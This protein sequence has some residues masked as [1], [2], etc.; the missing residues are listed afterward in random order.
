[1]GC[2]GVCVVWKWSWFCGLGVIIIL[3]IKCWR[4]LSCVWFLMLFCWLLKW[5]RCVLVICFVLIFGLVWLICKVMV[6]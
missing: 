3:V 6:F 4:R 2:N 1:M 5:W